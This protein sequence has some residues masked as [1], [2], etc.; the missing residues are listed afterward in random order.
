MPVRCRQ[1]SNTGISFPNQQS[2]NYTCFIHK[3]DSAMRLIF[4]L[5][6]S[7][8]IQG[9]IVCTVIS[10]S[11]WIICLRTSITLLPSDMIGQQTSSYKVVPFD[12]YW[13]LNTAMKYHCTVYFLAFTHCMVCFSWCLICFS[14]LL[15]ALR[16]TSLT[17]MSSTT[18]MRTI[19]E[20]FDSF[21]SKS[22]VKN[23]AV[24]YIHRGNVVVCQDILTMGK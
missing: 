13:H 16:P 17:G 19:L 3:F 23:T 22:I 18:S 20:T 9:K 24:H 4:W 5:F 12:A 10:I 7:S 2:H 1:C 21:Q 11:D 6:H 15:S 8:A 14:C